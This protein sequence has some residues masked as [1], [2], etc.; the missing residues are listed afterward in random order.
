MARSGILISALFLLLFFGC[1]EDD[2]VSSLSIDPVQRDENSIEILSPSYS[3][4]WLPGTTHK[5]EWSF[6]NKV[7][8]VNIILFRKNL[9]V[10]TIQSNLENSSS[11]N[12]MVPPDIVY[13]HHYRIKVVAASGSF[14]ESFSDF[15]YIIGDY[16]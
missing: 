6:E 11:Y 5:I 8:K 13:S 14:A 4:N 3:E 15:F 1:R 9:Q 16:N 2:D 10:L 7:E 12:W